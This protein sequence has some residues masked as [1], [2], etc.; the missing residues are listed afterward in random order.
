MDKDKLAKLLMATFLEELDEHV[1]A[2]NRDLLALE[3]NPSAADRA[4]LWKVLFRS[5]HSLKGAA[6][7]D[8][9]SVV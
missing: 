2:L 1:R 8:R 7:A 4:E 9:K 6:R 5:A 3:Q